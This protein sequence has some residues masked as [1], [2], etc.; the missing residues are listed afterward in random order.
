MFFTAAPLDAEKARE[1]M[2][3]DHL[4]EARPNSRRSTLELAAGMAAKSPMAIAVIK[5]QLRVLTD[6]QP[7]AAQVYETFSGPRGTLRQ[8]RLS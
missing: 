1:W 3:V 8:Q 6:Y 2:V 7:I 4:V 5:E